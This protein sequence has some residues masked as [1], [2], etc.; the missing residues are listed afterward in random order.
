MATPGLAKLISKSPSGANR[1]VIVTIKAPTKTIQ[2]GSLFQT[3]KANIITK[4]PSISQASNVIGIHLILTPSFIEK[5]RHGH[6]N[7]G[8]EVLLFNGIQQAITHDLLFDGIL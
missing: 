8:I 5:S 2:A 4:I 6:F 3:N 1:S 7:R